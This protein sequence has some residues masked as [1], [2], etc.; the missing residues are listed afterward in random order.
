MNR[1][2][3]ERDTTAKKRAC[4]M[5]LLLAWWAAACYAPPPDALDD[6]DGALLP[7]TTTVGAGTDAA[8]G[9]GGHGASPPGEGG[10][11]GRAPVG[12]GGSM[13]TT[14]ASTTATTSGTT[15]TG[16]TAGSTTTGNGGGVCMSGLTTGSSGHD[17]CISSN[18]CTQFNS[19]AS[20]PGCQD[21]LLGTGTGCDTNPLYDAYA[22][23][24]ETACPTEVCGTGISF[25][26]ANGDPAF[27]CVQCAEDNCCTDYTTCTGTGSV[28]DVNQCITCLNN[29]S[30]PACLSAPGAVQAAAQSA[31]ACLENQCAGPCGF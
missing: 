22:T 21:C 6:D 14:G 25:T 29:A 1:T 9:A 11:G 3:K 23:C 18:C 4:A 12:S 30:A 28:A 24:D 20:D 10:M 5:G 15:T 17:A 8:A 31:N 19:C 16:A 13:Q 27:A 7:A 2:S 26:D